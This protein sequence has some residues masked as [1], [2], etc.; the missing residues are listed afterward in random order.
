MLSVITSHGESPPRATWLVSESVTDISIASALLWEFR[1]FKTSFKETSSLRDRL[2]AQ[3]IQTGAAGATVALIVLVAFLANKESNVPT[4]IAYILGRIYCLTMLAN[5]NLRG[6][7]SPDTWLSKFTFSSVNFGTRGERG[8]QARSEGGDDYG[9]IHVHRTAVV[10]IETPQEFPMGSLTTNP[11]QGRP[12]PGPNVKTKRAV[13][14]PA[15][16]S[17]DDK[18][19]LSVE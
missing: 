2:V 19:D 7:G 1:K 16:Y 8:T 11:G 5:L 12:N 18:Q 13:N 9:G 15:S 14:V 3:T 6:T 17:S 4:G 10:H